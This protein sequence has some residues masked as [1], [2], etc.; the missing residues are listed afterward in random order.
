MNH[1]INYEG[2]AQEAKSAR[3]NVEHLAQESTRTVVSHIVGEHYQ[4]PKANATVT[5]HSSASPAGDNLPAYAAGISDTDRITVEKLID[6]TFQK[7]LEA[8]IDAARKNPSFIIDLYHDA[9]ADKLSAEL[10]ER[11]LL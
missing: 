7:G 1:N 10:E 4:L 6:L 2:L 3:E 8:G 5:Q 9:L 11:G